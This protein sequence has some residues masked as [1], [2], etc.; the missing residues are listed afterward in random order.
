MVT[1]LQTQQ[2]I[3]SWN[4]L[5]S[6][7]LRARSHRAS[8]VL[9]SFRLLGCCDVICMASS[10]VLCVPPLFRSPSTAVPV[11]KVWECVRALFQC[12][13]WSHN[14]TARLSAEEL[15]S[16]AESRE[17]TAS[18]HVSK[19]LLQRSTLRNSCA[20]TTPDKTDIWHVDKRVA[21]SVRRLINPS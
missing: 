5:Q 20:T 17:P 14:V 12:K 15:L 1:L 4:E 11:L 18:L 7:K 10:R 8:N 9:F 21:L 2:S 19:S 6:P 3:F 16:D 13:Y